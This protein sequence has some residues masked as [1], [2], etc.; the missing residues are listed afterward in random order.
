MRRFLRQAAGW[1]PLFALA[2]FFAQFPEA[3]GTP[4][5]YVLIDP[6]MTRV[7]VAPL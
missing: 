4:F 1:L 7:T 2:V 5:A 3:A 6:D